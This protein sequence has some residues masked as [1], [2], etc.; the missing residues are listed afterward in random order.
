MDIWSYGHI[1]MW[2]YGHVDIWA[3][4]HMEMWTYG[5][6]RDREEKFRGLVQNLSKPGAVKAYMES[7][8][9]YLID[10]YIKKKLYI[11]SIRF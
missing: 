9:L 11:I 7:L 2:T 6:N 4:R 10:Y 8:I 3:F 5:H 1:D